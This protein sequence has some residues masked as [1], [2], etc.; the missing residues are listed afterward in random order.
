MDNKIRRLEPFPGIDGKICES[1]DLI[2]HSKYA[3]KSLSAND[4]DHWQY[5]YCL[6]VISVR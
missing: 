6:H 5:K 3:G 2:D 4:T 1:T